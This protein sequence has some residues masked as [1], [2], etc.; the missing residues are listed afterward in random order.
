MPCSQ[1]SRARYKEKVSCCLPFWKPPPW[2]VVEYDTKSRF[3][4]V[5]SQKG[6]RGTRKALKINAFISYMLHNKKLRPLLPEFF[7]ITLRGIRTLTC[8]A[9]HKLRPA[10]GGAVHCTRESP[11][12]F[13]APSRPH[14]LWAGTPATAGARGRVMA[15][16]PPTAYVMPPVTILF[17]GEHRGFELHPAMPCTLLWACQQRPPPLCSAAQRG[18]GKGR[19]R[20]GIRPC[21]LRPWCNP[22]TD[23]CCTGADLQARRSRCS[24]AGQ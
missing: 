4:R 14:T 8:C 7:V 23:A 24:C 1:K 12:G 18:Q 15:A 19:K 16:K 5:G 17:V 20:A 3:A 21:L 9:M 6:S 13:R 2:C 11:V 10:R 22:R